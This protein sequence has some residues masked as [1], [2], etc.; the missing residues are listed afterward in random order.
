MSC[1]LCPG[2]LLLFSFRA[3]EEDENSSLK[4]GLGELLCWLSYFLQ[5]SP[6]RLVCVVVDCLKVRVTAVCV[7]L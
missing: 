6:F 5:V 1:N 2:S 4:S 7:P 3:E